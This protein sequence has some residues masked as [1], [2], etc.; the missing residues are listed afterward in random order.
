MALKPKG[1]RVGEEL[2]LEEFFR[3][4]ETINEDFEQRLHRLSDELPDA[5]GEAFQTNKG[6]FRDF[7]VLF[8]L[9][10][11]ELEIL[12]PPSQAE[13]DFDELLSA[14]RD[15]GEFLEGL[16]DGIEGADSSAE[17]QRLLDEGLLDIALDLVQLGVMRYRDACQSLRELADANDIV[18]SSARGIFG[19]SQIGLPSSEHVP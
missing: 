5:R 12:N 16:A 6:F 11:D 7:I 9:S 19:E 2:T 15:L 13:D 10:V 17:A 4:G 1:F 14:G 18:V 3:Q 8:A